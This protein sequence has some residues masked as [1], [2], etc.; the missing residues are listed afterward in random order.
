MTLVFI[1]SLK[2]FSK[3][4]G[5]IFNL[6]FDCDLGSLIHSFVNLQN[7]MENIRRCENYSAAN[8]WNRWSDEIE[9]LMATNYRLFSRIYWCNRAFYINI[10]FIAVIIGCYNGIFNTKSMT[11]GETSTPPTQK[12]FKSQGMEQR[13]HSYHEKRT[14]LK[15]SR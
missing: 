7:L 1:I 14:I 13:D 2:D 12:G 4:R 8:C 10:N 3:F 15:H 11:I 6:R 9:I 5:E